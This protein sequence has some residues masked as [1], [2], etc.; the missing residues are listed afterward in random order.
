MRWR[1]YQRKSVHEPQLTT[2]YI[3][4]QVEYY[5][6]PSTSYIYVFV[7]CSTYRMIAFPFDSIRLAFNLWLS[8]FRNVLIAHTQRLS[9]TSS[10]LARVLTLW[11]IY[12][13]HIIYGKLHIFFSLAHISMHPASQPSSRNTHDQPARTCIDGALIWKWKQN[14]EMDA[15]NNG[16]DCKN[17]QRNHSDLFFPL[18]FQFINGTMR[19][20]I[21]KDFVFAHEYFR[22]MSDSSSPNKEEGKLNMLF[23]TVLIIMTNE[24]RLFPKT[25]INFHQNLLN[26]LRL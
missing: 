10:A 21:R 14:S 26:R 17:V 16:C 18:H 2:R 4:N 9:L 25:I 22:M 13:S 15:F 3:A 23:K 11:Y 5:F 7:L 19:N 1:Q 6:C 8:L 20:W 12:Y 24:Y